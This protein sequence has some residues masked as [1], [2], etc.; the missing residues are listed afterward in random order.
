M[1]ALER[2][3]KSSALWE[4][5]QEKWQLWMSMCETQTFYFIQRDWDMYSRIK[6]DK[7]TVLAEYNALM[8]QWEELQK[9]PVEVV[10]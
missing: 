6:T 3:Q 2:A 9:Q 5:A 7:A 4:Q 8:Q 10:S 1:T